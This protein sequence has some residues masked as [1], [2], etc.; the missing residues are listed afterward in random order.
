MIATS[1]LRK[2]WAGHTA[3]EALCDEVDRL[4]A[5]LRERDRWLQQIAIALNTDPDMTGREMMQPDGLMQR[6]F[7]GINAAGRGR[8]VARARVAEVEAALAKAAWWTQAL[9][10]NDSADLIDAEWIL[11]NLR[12]V[13]SATTIQEEQE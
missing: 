12:A 1:E 4:R 6:I 13:L 7:E 8:D 11:R 5:D 3:V 9:M 2:T 10:N